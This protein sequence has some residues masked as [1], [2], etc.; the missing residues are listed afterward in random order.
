[1]VTP[2]IPKRRKPARQS[3]PKRYV[4]DTSVLVSGVNSADEFHLP[5]YQWIRE[6]FDEGAIFVVPA[7]AFFEFQAAQSRIYRPRKRP[8]YRELRLH[9]G[10]ARLYPM[11]R[12]FLARTHEAGLYDKF[13]ML[14][15]A[16]LVFACIAYLERLPLVTRDSAFDQYEGELQI[17]NPERVWSGWRSAAGSRQ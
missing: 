14:R 10:N 7:L 13:E 16:D 3:R 15:G 2:R 6:R 8:A 4:V 11:G 17:I 9:E 12:R 5:C 1:M